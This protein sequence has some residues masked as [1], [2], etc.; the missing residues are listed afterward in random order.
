MHIQL[1]SRTPNTITSYD[2]RQLIVNGITYSN[3][4]ILSTQTI[5]SPWSIHSLNELTPSAMSEIIQQNPEVILIGHP[6]SGTQ[7]PIETR[8]WL[9]QQRIGIECMDIG[10]ACRTFNV[11][12][13][14]GRAIVAGFI[15]R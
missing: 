14:E 3:S 4:M 13:S 5:I 9:S 15:I 6:E 7:P 10:A 8:Q 11:L 2:D 1:E 12:L